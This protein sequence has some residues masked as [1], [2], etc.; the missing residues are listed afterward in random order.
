MEVWSIGSVWTME[1]FRAGVK[2][3][4]TETKNIMTLE[5]RNYMLNAGLLAATAITSWYILIYETNTTP[6]EDTTY[7]VPVFTECTAYSETTRSVYTGVTATEGLMTNA[8]SKGTFTFTADKT[9]YG[10]ALVGGG[11]SA[12]TKGN[13]GGGGKMLCAALFAD[14]KSALVDDILRVTVAIQLNS[15]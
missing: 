14:P 9:V 10:G 11:T 15:A 6:T 5:G 3:W 8:A 12:S 2:V 13:V 4:E 1:C 7:A